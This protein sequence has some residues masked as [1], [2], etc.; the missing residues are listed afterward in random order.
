MLPGWV[1]ISALVWDCLVRFSFWETFLTLGSDF[2]TLTL[3]LIAVPSICSGK[4]L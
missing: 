1:G 2:F 3:T 4:S